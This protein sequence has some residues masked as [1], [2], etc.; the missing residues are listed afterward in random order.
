MTPLAIEN[1][2]MRVGVLPDFGARV[3]SLLDKANGR[4]WIFQGGI[5][6]ETG[7]DAVF[8]AAEAVGW[9]E[10]FPTVSPCDATGRMWGRR[11]RDHGDL[12]GRPWAVDTHTDATLTTTRATAEFAFTR[13]LALAGPTL[14]ATYRVEN[15]TRSEMPFLWALH[16]LLAAPP[17]DRIVLPGVT[18]LSATYVSRGREGFGAAFNEPHPSEPHGELVEPGGGRAAGPAPVLRQAQVEGGL[19]DQRLRGKKAGAPTVPWPDTRRGLGF[20]LDEVQPA[21]AGFAGKFYGQPGEPRAAVGG[22]GQWLVIGWSA[23][24]ATIGLWLNYHGWPSPPQGH[25]LALEPTT[26]PVDHLAAALG[27][28]RA[29]WIAPGASAEWTITLTLSRTAP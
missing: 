7:E 25:H 28:G 13:R 29:A 20:R 2:A 14:T 27:T 24:L 16:G 1:A 23:P 22:D 5:S 3:V 18:A 9:D 11:L 6:H 26:A 12:W 15:R 8:G 4:E 19:K 10:C 17:G 21:A